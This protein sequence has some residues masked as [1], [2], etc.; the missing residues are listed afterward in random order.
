MFSQDFANGGASSIREVPLTT[1]STN[2][3]KDSGSTSHD[4]PRRN[5]HQEIQ[6]DGSEGQSRAEN[7][8]ANNGQT[9]KADTNRMKRKQNSM[10]K[11]SEDNNGD[12]GDNS[13]EEDVNG[14]SK[15]TRGHGGLPRFACPFFKRNPQ[16][17]QDCQ[18][19][20]HHWPNVSRIKDHLYKQHM[21]H[22]NQCNRCGSRFNN[23]HGLRS[24]QRQAVPCMVR[25]LEYDEGI[26]HCTKSKL[27]DKKLARGS[28]EEEKWYAVY[29]ILFLKMT[30]QHIRRLIAT[31]FREVLHSFRDEGQRLQS[32]FHEHDVTLASPS[33]AIG[34]GNQEPAQPI[35]EQGGA[36]P[37]GSSPEQFTAELIDEHLQDILEEE[38]T[39][40]VSQ[41]GSYEPT[42]DLRFFPDS[43]F[44]SMSSSEQPMPTSA[45]ES[46]MEGIDCS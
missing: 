40:F 18:S 43:G 21:L 25:D 22:D 29:G 39:Q 41:Y 46:D 44:E 13:S 1:S 36:Q 42:E 37:L 10:K 34:V 6:K 27:Q 26:D 31:R 15:R 20:L 2:N 32:E 28:T 45:Q 23:Q 17:Y 35:A 33:S 24:H 8:V 4:P 38:L 14:P 9:A 11:I 16:L 12:D 3:Q 7:A 30:V 5:R 19:C